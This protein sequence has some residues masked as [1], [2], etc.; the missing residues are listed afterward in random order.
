MQNEGVVVSILLG[1]STN[2]VGESNES[3]TEFFLLKNFIEGNSVL[4]YTIKGIREVII[5]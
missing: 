2:P 1:S 4:F 5:Q 3:L